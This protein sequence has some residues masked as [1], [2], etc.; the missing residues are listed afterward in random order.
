MRVCKLARTIAFLP[1]LT[2][3][4]HAQVS[5]LPPAKFVE[6]AQSRAVL[7]G[8][9]QMAVR[10]HQIT[11][12]VCNGEHVFY[13][14]ILWS[15][16]FMPKQPNIFLQALKSDVPIPEV[17]KRK[18]HVKMHSS[19]NTTSLNLFN[20]FAPRVSVNSGKKYITIDEELVKV[21]AIEPNSVKIEVGNKVLTG[22]VTTPYYYHADRKYGLPVVACGKKTETN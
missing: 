11:L 13:N 21:K 14:G 4:S 20:P 17:Y 19:S 2:L 10:L 7:A 1:V 9:K 18:V 8:Y 3:P 12:G 6:T 16:E 15:N 5:A 22:I